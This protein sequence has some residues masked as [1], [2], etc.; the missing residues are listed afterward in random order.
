M[1]VFIWRC[2]LAAGRL[3]T[4][5]FVTVALLLAA[6]ALAAGAFSDQDGAT[7]GVQGGRPTCDNAVSCNST[8]NPT[9]QTKACPP[10]PGNGC[11]QL[12]ATPCERGHGNVEA[13][14]KH[15]AETMAPTTP[16]TPTTPSSP[17]SG[18]SATSPANSP[19][20]TPAAGVQPSTS[21]TV[22][23]ATAA[24]QVA[25][26]GTSKTHRGATATPTTSATTT[27]AAPEAPTATPVTAPGHFTG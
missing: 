18:A 15:C 16:T 27:T 23:A 4:T 9:D 20:S 7:S 10:N 22:P 19:P 25:V 24:P 2:R 17:S 5:L 21:A 26:K 6:G 12:G 8:L 14:N 11:H 1:R 3:G 13:H